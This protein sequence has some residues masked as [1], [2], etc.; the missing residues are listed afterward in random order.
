MNSER[1]VRPPAPPVGAELEQKYK[2]FAVVTG[3][4]A[5]VFAAVMAVDILNDDEAEVPLSFLSGDVRPK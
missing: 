5:H 2:L 1:A 4:V 3:P